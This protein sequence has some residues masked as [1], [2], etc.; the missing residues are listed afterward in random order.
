MRHLCIGRQSAAFI[1]RGHPWLR[2]DRFTGSLA[3]LDN[4]DVVTLC[5]EQRRPLASALIDREHPTICA[6]VF[7]RQGDRD[8]DPVA[9]CTRALQQRTKLLSQ[10]DTNCLRLIHGEGD[11][12]PG[13]RVERLGPAL[14]VVVM[15]CCIRPYVERIASYC[16]D[17]CGIPGHQVVIREH[18]DDQ[19]RKPTRARMLDGSPL[20]PDWQVPGQE[21]GVPVCVQPAA[22]LATGIYVDQRGTR[23]WLAQR[24]AGGR[25]LNLF[26]Y[27]G[28]FSTSMLVAGAAQAVSVDLSA[29][30][31][32]LA[33]EN[34]RIAQVAER[35]QVIHG[36][37]LSFC[38][39]NGEQYDWIICDP[40]TAA[41]GGRGWVARRDYPKLLQAMVPLLSPQ[42]YMLACVNTLGKP[43]DLGRALGAAG[44]QTLAPERAPQLEEDI[45]QRKGF[46]EGRPYQLF[47]AQHA[48]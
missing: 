46:H 23:R 30:A 17:Y 3:G 44:L 39:E 26:A 29:P 1:S 22:G 21:L 14:H 12:L 18:L 48:S 10:G 11:Y 31:L 43:Y 15:S 45:P 8:F 16:A 24:C 40:P 33:Q 47:V 32:A 13:I 9:A 2:K 4:G 42:G 20:D 35:H 28:L 7:H 36:D 6:R 38:Q 25:V 41:Q 37:C 5:D 34:A 27:T 19:R